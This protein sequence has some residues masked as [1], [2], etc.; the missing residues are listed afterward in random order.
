MKQRLHA[1]Q[2]AAVGISLLYVEDDAE[3]RQHYGHFLENFFQDITYAKDG[4]EG[5]GFTREREFDL[6]ISD[7]VMPHMSGLDMIKTIKKEKPSQVVIF[8]SA[9]S[10][11]AMLESAIGIGV[12]GYLF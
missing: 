10:D 4:Q 1:L 8:V 6:I 5:L 7:I 2:D 11:T 9:Y 3:I 12:D